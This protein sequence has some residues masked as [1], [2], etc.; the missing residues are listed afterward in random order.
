MAKP[1]AIFRPIPRPDEEHLLTA[2]AQLLGEPEWK[3]T[4]MK[5]TAN[6]RNWYVH[7]LLPMLKRD[8]INLHLR[9][10]GGI[11]YSG[12]ALSIEEVAVFVGV[13]HL[14]VGHLTR[15]QPKA[16]SRKPGASDG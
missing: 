14:A 12:Q 15:K 2:L 13:Q 11:C 3:P 7:E 16:S 8:G 10:N 1:T 6:R 4:Y 9:P 5:D